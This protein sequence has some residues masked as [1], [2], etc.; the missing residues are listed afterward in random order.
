M[1]NLL[2]RS[3]IVVVV[4]V[5]TVVYLGKAVDLLGVLF[6]QRQLFSF[7]G[8]PDCQYNVFVG[9]IYL[10]GCF[11]YFGFIYFGFNGRYNDCVFLVMFGNGPNSCATGHREICEQKRP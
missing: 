8:L 4:I 5:I 3:V 2:L 11:I 1:H 10:G 6:D 7:A 9:S